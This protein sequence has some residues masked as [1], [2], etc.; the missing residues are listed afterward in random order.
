MMEAGWAEPGIFDF[1]AH[2]PDYLAGTIAQYRAWTYA[3]MFGILVAETGLIFFGWLPG[4]TMLFTAGLLSSS[5][6]ALDVRVVLPLMS[7][8]AFAGDQLNYLMGAALARKARPNPGGKGTRS[9]GTRP[10]SKRA[11]RVAGRLQK[12]RDAYARHGGQVVIIGRFIPVLSSIA[13]LGAALSGM[14]YRRF[15]R[16][17]AAGC[18]LWTCAFTLSGFF[19][20]KI[21][22]VR[23][24]FW[25]AIFGVIMVSILS[26]LAESW[27][28]GRHPARPGPDAA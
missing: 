18:L 13:P 27:W 4:D 17:S 6:H 20:G 19:F 16:F 25:A 28:Q 12:A 22:Q 10:R 23:E 1:L 21:P 3:V 5:G 2:F 9:K 11:L 8:A 7:L 14:G 15:S 26:A 24:H